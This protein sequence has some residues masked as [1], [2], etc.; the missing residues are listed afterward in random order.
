M[1]PDHRNGILAGSNN[2]LRVLFTK[3]PAVLV[4]MELSR[5]IISEINDQ[6]VVYLREVSG[7]RAFPIL[8]GLFEATSINRRLTAPAPPRPLTHELLRQVIEQMGGDLQDIVVTRMV[9]HT[10][11]AELRIRMPDGELLAV[12]S[13]PSD[14]ISLAVHHEPILPIYVSQEVLDSVA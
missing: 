10:Y 8:I 2:T 4:E 3:V 12:D 5:I 6:Q 7:D 9:D 14:A 1:E 11:Y 13:R